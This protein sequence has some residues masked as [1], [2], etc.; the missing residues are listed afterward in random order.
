LAAQSLKRLLQFR[1]GGFV[2]LL[3]TDLTLHLLLLNHLVHCRALSIVLSNNPTTLINI[4]SAA[5]KALAPQLHRGGGTQLA[6]GRKGVEN[7]SVENVLKLLLDS[8][9]QM[10]FVQPVIKA[11]NSFQWSRSM[12]RKKKN[13]AGDQGTKHVTKYI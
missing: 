1:V 5:S 12:G 11:K 4:F 2:L 3:L 6:V 10:I 7:I 13:I 9:T 8:V